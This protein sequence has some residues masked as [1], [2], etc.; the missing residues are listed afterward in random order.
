VGIDG[1]FYIITA[2]TAALLSL[3]FWGDAFVKQHHVESGMNQCYTKFFIAD[4]N[5]FY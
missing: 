2:V 4:F 3:N 1:N 5:L